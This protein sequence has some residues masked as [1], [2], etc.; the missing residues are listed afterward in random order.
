MTQPDG[1]EIG[2]SLSSLK[3]WLVAYLE[4]D[5]VGAASVVTEL[6]ACELEPVPLEFVAITV[7]V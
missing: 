2:V 3:D 4:T 5:N 7:K 1:I 6:D